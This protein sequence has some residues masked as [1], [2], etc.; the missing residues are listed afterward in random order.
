VAQGG[1]LLPYHNIP[2]TKKKK[3]PSENEK[4]P[5]GKKVKEEEKEGGGHRPGK[6]ANENITHH[7]TL[8]GS[9]SW[10]KTLG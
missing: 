5:R 6:Q 9:Q 10:R 8:Q 2:S 3:P 1:D 7:V 4:T